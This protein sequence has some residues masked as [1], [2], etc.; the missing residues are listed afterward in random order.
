MDVA[1]IGWIRPEEKFDNIDALV[2]QMKVDSARARDA[3]KRSGGAFP[4]LGMI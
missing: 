2:E 4:P 3:L 1:L